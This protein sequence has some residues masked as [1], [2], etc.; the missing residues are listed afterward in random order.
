MSMTINACNKNT[1]KIQALALLLYY[2]AN[3]E[4]TLITLDLTLSRGLP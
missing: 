2:Y 4:F 1:R 3:E